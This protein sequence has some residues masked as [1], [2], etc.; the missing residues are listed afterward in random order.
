MTVPA[1]PLLPLSGIRV[2]DLGRV[3]AA[4]YCTQIL[5]DLG[6]EVIKIEQLGVGDAMRGHGHSVIKDDAGDGVGLTPHFLSVNRSKKSIALDI[7]TEGGQKIVRDLVSISDIFIENFKV[8]DLARYGLDYASLKAIRPDLIYCSITGFGQSGPYSKRP[9]TDG[10]F[11]AM[12]GMMSITGARGGP[13]S[14]ISLV[15][16]DIITGIYAASAIQAALRVREVQGGSG[17]HIDLALL[18]VAI[19]TMS[20]QAEHYLTTGDIPV[21]EGTASPGTAPAQTFRCKDG[22]ILI[23]ASA[24]GSFRALCRIIGR[25]DL[26]E[27]EEFKTP[28]SRYRY[29]DLLEPE[30]SR[31][32]AG[33]DV[34]PLY[35]ALIDAGVICAPV[36]NLAQTFADPQVQHRGVVQ[37][38][39]EALSGQSLPLI[40]NPIRFSDTPLP[41][42]SAPPRMGAD[43]A[44]VLG[45]LLGYDAAMIAELKAS[46]A[47]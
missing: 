39:T 22:D 21:A 34:A 42:G 18:D 23:Q 12:S 11:Q 26:L 36:Y 33:W 45:E 10:V 13:P 29:L 17:Q 32:V 24:N 5:A 44:M 15:I 2:V 4:P 9:A 3:I 41:A 27:V 25:E 30:L 46:G 20:H 1:A 19:A 16:S 31:E 6:A 43:N 7:S 35:E 14:K 38:V 28:V 37:H 8:G 47:V 40:A